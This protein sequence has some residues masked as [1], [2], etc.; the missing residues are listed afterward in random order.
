M[1]QES[2]FLPCGQRLIGFLN[3]LAV[4]GLLL[5]VVGCGGSAATPT[6]TPAMPAWLTPGPTSTPGA[7]PPPQATATPPAYPVATP[8]G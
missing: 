3:V 1:G 4:L 7:Y 5:A 6:P 2:R 8:G